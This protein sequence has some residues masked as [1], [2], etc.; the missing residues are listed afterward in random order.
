MK[1]AETFRAWKERH[2]IVEIKY[3]WKLGTIVKI[4]LKERL[5]ETHRLYSLAFEYDPS[6]WENSMH[7]AQY[8]YEQELADFQKDD[9][10]IDDR[11]PED[12]KK[13]LQIR[14][15]K[16]K[17]SMESEMEQYPPFEITVTWWLDY[18]WNEEIIFEFS[19]NKENSNILREKRF[20]LHKYGIE[21]IPRGSF[22]VTDANTGVGE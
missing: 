1:T 8:N 11:N 9:K 12:L 16:Y 14:L 17:K 15:D 6:E 20:D 19:L 2:E 5:M 7:Q 13:N 18:K 21:M 22:E 3:N 4:K 10:L